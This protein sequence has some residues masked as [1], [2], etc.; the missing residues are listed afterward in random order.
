MRTVHCHFQWGLLIFSQWTCCWWWGCICITPG[1]LRQR[2]MTCQLW[3]CSVAFWMVFLVPQGCEIAW[4]SSGGDYFCL[5]FSVSWQL[6]SGMLA[7]LLSK[8]LGRKRLQHSTMFWKVGW[9][10]RWNAEDGWPTGLFNHFIP[11]HFVHSALKREA[12]YP[13]CLVQAGLVACS[14][15]SSVIVQMLER[16]KRQETGWAGE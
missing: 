12:C 6:S 7:G 1:S 14:V 3:F 15:E 13:F 10:K 5:A 9:G 16:L 8:G 2:P 11:H 4:L